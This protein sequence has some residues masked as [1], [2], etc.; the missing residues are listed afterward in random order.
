MMPGLASV[1]LTSYRSASMAVVN[2]DSLST[3][4]LGIGVQITGFPKLPKDMQRRCFRGTG[5]CRNYEFR[6]FRGFV[7]VADAGEFFEDASADL[8]VQPLVVALLIYFK[9][10]RRHR[11]IRLLLKA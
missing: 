8:S 6:L 11:L 2:P 1:R 5:F 10:H 9:V 7:R 3:R 4:T